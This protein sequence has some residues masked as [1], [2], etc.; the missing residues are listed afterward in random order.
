MYRSMCAMACVMGRCIM[1]FV[2]GM[3]RSMCAMMLWRALWLSHEVSGVVRC[4]LR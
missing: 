3:Y 2:A 1:A 4:L